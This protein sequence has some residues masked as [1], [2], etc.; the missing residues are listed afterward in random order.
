MK[1]TTLEA[2]EEW[3]GHRRPRGIAVWMAGLSKRAA[4]RR[5]QRRKLETFLARY[6]KCEA[7]IWDILKGEPTVEKLRRWEKHLKRLHRVAG[8]FWDKHGRGEG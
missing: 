4:W 8:K 2:I 3:T 1:P 6:Y 7:R 5:R